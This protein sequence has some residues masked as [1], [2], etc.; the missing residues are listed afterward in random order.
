MKLFYLLL[1]IVA[2]GF[3]SAQNT[4]WASDAARAEVP[5]LQVEF[6]TLPRSMDNSNSNDRTQLAVHFKIE[7]GWH[8][9]GSKPGD[10]GLPTEIKWKLPGEL[11]ASALLW[12][13]TKT[14]YADGLVSHG[15]EG[16]VTLVS[17]LSGSLSA[18][19]ET[20]VHL[21]ADVSWV[22]CKEEC[23]P[24][25]VTLGDE[26]SSKELRAM[27]KQPVE[28]GS[29]LLLTL[30]AAFLGGLLL[31]LMPCVFPVL[32]LKVFSFLEQKD[33]RSSLLHGILYTSGVLLSFWFLAGV[34]FA[35]RALGTKVGWGFQFQSPVFVAA[36]AIVLL[37]IALNFLGVFEFGFGIQRVA[38]KADRGKGYLGSFLSGTLSTLLATPCSAPFMATAIAAALAMSLIAAFGVFTALGLGL[39]FPYLVFALFP[40]LLRFLPRP[41][42]W[43]VRVRQ[44]LSLPL[45]ASVVW[46]L[47]ILS[48]QVGVQ[49]WGIF[50]QGVRS[51]IVSAGRE[52][53]EPFSTAR[54]DEL[55]RGQAPVLVEFTAAWCVTCQVNHH[56]L[57]DMPEVEQALREHDV[58]IL[59]A[60][61]TKNDPNITEALNSFGR[62]GVPLTALYLPTQEKPLILPQLLTASAVEDALNQTSLTKVGIPIKKECV[63]SVSEC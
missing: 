52:S 43:M 2:A 17:N 25:S 31:N 7:P 19:S 1:T 51:A 4:A 40:Q 48:L 35:L 37:L 60:D 27:L 28:H 29:S 23:I 62:S 44:V 18:S 47:W 24:G 46:L 38:G 26:I 6:F 50:R 36:M 63:G 34:L 22:L 42:N 12:P 54:L 56:V 11:A 59:I 53:A 15:Y 39:A 33:S 49:D 30:G 10:V 21:G 3:C 9:Y 61:W 55:L 14:F 5:H 58:R 57:F 16:E 20:D 41:G 32:S 8:I 45:F 13:K